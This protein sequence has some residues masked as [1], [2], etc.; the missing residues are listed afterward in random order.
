MPV[1]L[2]ETG[3]TNDY[4]QVVGQLQYTEGSI[5][6][7]GTFNTT[8]GNL[9]RAD[10]LADLGIVPSTFAGIRWRFDCRHDLTDYTGKYFKSA[11]PKADLGI[12][13]VC[14]SG[15][16]VS[17]TYINYA[18]QGTQTFVTYDTYPENPYPNPDLFATGVAEVE[19]LL[20]QVN[21]PI[22]QIGDEIYVRFL[23]PELV[24]QFVLNYTILGAVETPDSVG[25]TNFWMYA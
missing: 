19:Y 1:S 15:S 8:V 10:I 3:Y 23:Y 12:I 18:V 7:D 9:V 17:E 25:A 6:E 11:L 2:Y 24:K 13:N 4:F 20:I 16:C 21:S 5:F 22:P 14:S